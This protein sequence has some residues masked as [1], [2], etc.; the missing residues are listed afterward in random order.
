MKNYICI[1]DLQGGSFAVGQVMSS[2]AWRA[3]A[4]EWADSDE[5]IELINELKACPDEEIITFISN[6]WELDIIEY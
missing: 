1:A 6:I 3:Q 2:D 5:N 4:I